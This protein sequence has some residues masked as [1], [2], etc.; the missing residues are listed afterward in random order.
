MKILIIHTL[1]KPYN[2][3]GAER[4]C[5]Y[6]VN[7]FINEGND[8]S[9]LTTCDKKEKIKDEIID[10]IKVIRIPIKNIY[11]HYNKKRP[12]AFKRFIWHTVDIYNPF[13]ARAVER[14][15]IK[16]KPDIAI[17]HNITGFSSSLWRV[18]KKNKI[19]VIQVLHDLYSICPNSNMFNGRDVCKKRCFKCK[20]FRFMHP[21]LSRDVDAVVGVSRFVLDKHLE[22][23]LFKNA[24]IKTYIHNVLNVDKFPDIS[25][26]AN[27]K[28]IIFGFIGTLTT[29]KG[30]ENLLNAFSKFDLQNVEL[31]VAGSGKEDYENYLKNKY[32][33]DNIKFLGYQKQDD[34]FKKIDILIVP[35]LWNDTFPTVILESFIYGIPIIASK[36]GGIPEVINDNNG[37]LFEPTDL[38][39]LEKLIGDIILNRE[40]I[41][42]K[43]D[44]IILNREKYINY[45][46]WI[47][48]YMEVI[49]EIIKKR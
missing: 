32:R 42:S 18:F 48:K 11:W 37:W 10:S 5:E 8:V 2:I 22:Y 26:K 33:K 12:N 43:K 13:M 27:N 7:G 16:E 39:S 34:F 45:N 35:S 44:Y 36:R 3:G 4:I 30:I 14:I 24:R 6:M 17:C 20:V 23:G 28:K 15:I 46:S 19:P 1:Y 38:N 40:K 21:Y 9:V 31:L 41:K 29:A 25:K 47:S 49:N